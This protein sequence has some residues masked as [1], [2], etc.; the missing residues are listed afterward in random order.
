MFCGQAHGAGMANECCLPRGQL[1]KSNGSEQSHPGQ[2]SGEWE[3]PMIMS[4]SLDVLA[5]SLFKFIKDRGTPGWILLVN[6]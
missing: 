6:L 5:G 3:K 2:R 1:R 4:M